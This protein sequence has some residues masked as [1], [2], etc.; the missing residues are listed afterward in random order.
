LD[1]LEAFAALAPSKPARS[2]VGVKYTSFVAELGVTLL[3]GQLALALVAFDGL[4]PCEL[5]TELRELGYRI[6]GPVE[7]I[8]PEARRVLVVVAGA[9]A[10]KTYVIGAL[11]ALHL[12]LTCPLTTLAPGEEAVAAIIAPDPRQR[13]QA[14]N[15]VTGAAQRHPDI[16]ALIEGE[17]G[18]DSFT[19]RRADGKVLVESVPA[20]RGGT[21]GRGRSLV[22]ALL[23]EAAFFMDENFVVND[24]EVFRGVQPRV[25][26]GG[27]AIISSTPW[28]EAGLLHDEFLANHPDPRCAI[29]HTTH[30]GHPHRA[31]AAHAPTLLLRDVEETRQI[32]AAEEARD[33]ANAAREYGAQFLALGAMV[34][35]DARSIA[36]AVDPTIK[37][38]Q[39]PDPSPRALHAVGADLGFVKDAAVGVACERTPTVY[40]VVAYTELLPSVQRLKPSEVFAAFIELARNYDAEEMVGD[41]HYAEAAREAFL[42]EGLSFIEVPGGQLG[43]AEIFSVVNRLLSERV[44]KLPDDPRLLQQLREVKKR[45]R[46]GGGY[47]IEQPR[48]S[49]GG[50]GDIVSA[51]VAGLWRLAELQIPPEHHQ[52]FHDHRLAAA[53]AEVD[54][55]R[56]VDAWESTARRLAKPHY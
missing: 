27:Q 44:L 9:R 55:R 6:F 12:A 40:R 51:M 42:D 2:W 17:V 20:K 52:V 1:A 41:G 29:P 48:K 37:L 5:P 4:E 35:F 14:Y 18:K 19:L 53:V 32:V 33:P 50:H 10:G 8:P 7:V 15:Y 31:I 13:R 28:A 46:P 45:P 39:H 36:E 11:R 25:L 34:F 30:R 54:E 24:V 49:K 38:G 22:C 43:K 56:S 47:V 3:P 26:T 21:A 16:A 23:E